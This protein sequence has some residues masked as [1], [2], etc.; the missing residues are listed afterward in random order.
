[1]TETGLWPISR[2]R[3]TRADARARASSGRR[4]LSWRTPAPPAGLGPITAASA[5]SLDLAA[6]V[7]RHEVP[8]RGLLEQQLVEFQ[9]RADLLV[10]GSPDGVGA[11][12]QD[13]VAGGNGLIDDVEP[14]L[15]AHTPE[16][17]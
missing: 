4:N 8:L 16:I 6:H 1:M 11:V 2:V 14:H 15:I 9:R 5:G 17:D 7:G 10:G 3:R 13:V 12:V